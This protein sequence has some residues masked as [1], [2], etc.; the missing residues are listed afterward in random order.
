MVGYQK[1]NKKTPPQKNRGEW[2]LCSPSLSIPE[3]RDVPPLTPPVDFEPHHRRDSVVS[4]ETT[5][6]RGSD[7]GFISLLILSSRGVGLLLL[8]TAGEAG[9]GTILSSASGY[10][11]ANSRSVTQD[12][13]RAVTKMHKGAFICI[14]RQA[15]F[16]VSIFE[17]RSNKPTQMLREKRSQYLYVQWFQMR[18][19]ISLSDSKTRWKPFT[20]FCL[21]F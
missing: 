11:W 5:Q 1:Q 16:N 6:P 19:S 13:S 21:Q 8:V 7:A 9:G 18:K 10:R 12:L 17:K 15:G 20:C 14:G 3:G 2:P 4:Q